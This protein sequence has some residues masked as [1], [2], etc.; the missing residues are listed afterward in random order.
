MTSIIADWDVSAILE[1]LLFVSERPLTTED[2][3]EVLYHQLGEEREAAADAAADARDAAAK[4]AVSMDA[5]NESASAEAAVSGELDAAAASDAALEVEAAAETPADAA[6]LAAP[7][8]ATKD[9]SHPLTAHADTVEGEDAVEANPDAALEAAVDAE[10]RAEISEEVIR[11]E[12]ASR[13]QAA[14]ERM[15]SAYQDESRLVGR[16]FELVVIGDGYQIRTR[17][18]AGGFIRQFLQAKPTRLSR[19]Q[20]ETLAIVAY[21]Q[22]VTKPEIEDI[23]GVDCSNA[24]RALLERKLVR[25]L[26]KKEEVG[27]PLIYGTSKE[28][29][30]FFRLPSLLDLPTLREFQ[31]LSDEHRRRVEEELDQEAPL[32][33]FKELADSAPKLETDDTELLAAVDGALSSAKQTVQRVAEIT[34]LASGEDEREPIAPPKE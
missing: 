21:R 12:I 28:F 15:L 11:K 10:E 2:M 23:R 32:G 17:P 22:P 27:R 4:T 20:L 24:I 5:E 19:A 26:G 9:E 30:E 16:G 33:S 18:L 29:L 3:V 13:V 8:A 31:E 1:G 7:V 14:L 25:I 34:G 6:P